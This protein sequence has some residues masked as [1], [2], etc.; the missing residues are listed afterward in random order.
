[1]FAVNNGFSRD[2]EQGLLASIPEDE[3]VEFCQDSYDE[4]PL[5][6]NCPLLNRRVAAIAGFAIIGAI[7]A[8]DIS[9]GFVPS[10]FRS[11]DNTNLKP[12]ITAHDVVVFKGLYLTSGVFLSLT[13]LLTGATAFYDEIPQSL[14][15]ALTITAFIGTLFEVMPFFIIL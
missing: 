9:L 11:P 14:T 15:T 5:P 13:S 7:G 1:M 2:L 6:W 8:F 3:E 12:A 10:L 4:A